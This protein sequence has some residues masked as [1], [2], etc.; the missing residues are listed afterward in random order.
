MDTL[1][2]DYSKLMA[3]LQSGTF[4]GSIVILS[5]ALIMLRF[6]KQ[7]LIKK[8]AYSG[9][10]EQHKNTF[11]GMIFGVLQ[12]IV[13]IC[14]VVL[15]LH[16]NGVNVASILAG[17]GIMATIIGL[18]LQDTLKDIIAGIS[19]YNNNFYKVGDMVRWNGE[20]CDVSY[21][22]ARVTKFR[23]VTTNS[24]YTVNNSV[25]TSIEKIKDQF[26][27]SY[28]FEFETPKEKI[29]KA[30]ERICERARE[31]VKYLKKISY[32]GIVAIDEEGVRYS[33]M[34]NCPAHKAGLIR[35][36]VTQIVYE[37]LKAHK[38]RPLFFMDS[39]FD[40]KP[41]KKKQ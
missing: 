21:F 16:L 24:T 18:A 4:L 38:L 20:M 22:S 23:S 35:I 11:I 8:V 19:I 25:V 9:K 31:E 10:D 12:Y 36:Q 17:L 39:L 13:M 32:A 27:L 15:I 41:K 40:E 28:N 5:V 2:K 1:G 37:E 30:M 33:L 14:A 34:L 3:Y 29:D 26:F 7:Y 6:I